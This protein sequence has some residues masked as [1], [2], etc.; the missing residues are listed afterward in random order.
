M[1]RETPVRT[2]VTRLLDQKKAVYTA[3]GFPAKEAVSG[4]EAARLLGFP[5]ERVFKT[6]VTV[7]K[8]G[9]H[10]VFLV[11][12]EAEL[13]LRKAAAC[14]GEKKV[15]MLPQKELLPLTGYV[16]G[17]CS[18]IGMK[19]AFPTVLDAGAET[20][21][22][23]VFSAGRIGCHVEISPLELKKILDYRTADISAD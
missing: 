22:T 6:L 10:Y 2:N 12:V 20:L 8:S 21:E 23:L 3:H 9:G 13:D 16:H 15:D 19:K 5:P 14:V 17:G 1:S 4:A 11:P 7:G 18:P